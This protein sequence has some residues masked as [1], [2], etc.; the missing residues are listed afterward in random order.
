MIVAYLRVSTERQH[1][2]NQRNE[3]TKF[4]QARGITIDRWEKEVV[5]GRCRKED[6]NLGRLLKSLKAGDSL[7]V[8]ELSRLSRTLYDIMSVLNNC[9]ERKITVYSTKDGYA[10]DDSINS[11]VLAFAFGLVAEIERNLISLR[12][13]EALATRRQ[14]G[15]RLGRPASYRPKHRLLNE[16]REHIADLLKQGVPVKTICLRYGFSRS[17]FYKHWKENKINTPF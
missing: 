2:I 8:T 15:I 10:F 14:E 12:T 1:L 7:I 3:I 17:T 4:A 9:L 5:S 6:R 13:R 16:K 11:K